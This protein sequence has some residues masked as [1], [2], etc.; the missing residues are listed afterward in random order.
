MPCFSPEQKTA[1]RFALLD[2]RHDHITH[3]GCR[4]SVQAALN[5]LHGD[6]VQILGACVISAVNHGSHGET[7]GDAELRS[8]GLTG[9]PSLNTLA[10][11]QV[12]D[13]GFG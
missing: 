1:L 12:T 8:G 3:A 7:E 11:M 6:D 5:P 9:V 13:S 4:Q 10:W 2:G